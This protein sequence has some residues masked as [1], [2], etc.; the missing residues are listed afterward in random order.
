MMHILYMD[1]KGFREGA[2]F[3]LTR[4]KKSTT[5]IHLNR[6][7]K[8]NEKHWLP[9]HVDLLNEVYRVRELE[10]EYERGWRGG[11]SPSCSTHLI[12]LVLMPR[13]MQILS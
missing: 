12:A 13:Q 5:G 2:M 11:Y 10:L 7:R 1:D 4:L 9:G 8:D 6:G 3:N